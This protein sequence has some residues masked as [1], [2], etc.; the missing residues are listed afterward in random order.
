MTVAL[1]EA[2]LR[3]YY[4]AS[5]TPFIGGPYL[6]K[7][8]PK[9][10]F[11]LN[12]GIHTAQERVSYIVPISVNTIGMRGLEI[13]PKG[14]NFRIAMT[15]DSHI[16]GSGLTNKQT[17]PAQMQ[18]ALNALGSTN[19]F[20]VVNASGPSYN[21]VQQLLRIQTLLS[22]IDA[23]LLILAFNSENDI[24][25]NIE[26]LRKFMASNP[27]RPVARLDEDGKLHFDYTAPQRYYK[28][29]KWRLAAPKA[30]RP[31]Y[32][33]TALYVR[34]RVFWRSFGVKGVADPN[35]QLGL[36]HLP[37]FSA[38]HS[39]SGLSA[40]DY[41]ALWRDGWDVTAALILAMRE[42]AAAAGARFAITVLPSKI[43][44]N[45]ADIASTLVHYRGLK[46]DMTRINRMIE[47]FGNDH[48]IPVLETLKPLLA[49]R[50]AGQRGLHYQRFDSHM[51]PKSHRILANA[52]AKQLLVRKL[53]PVE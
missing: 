31:W 3:L 2:G 43:Q 1:S 19:R 37:A 45:K 25:Y 17:L 27:K 10:A 38:A 4:Y 42:S 16:F 32:E 7:P 41:E 33:S 39:P 34:G 14:N 29:H 49:A 5:L 11:T 53:V 8:D 35:I 26:G 44:V 50:D 23:D 13:G 36:P 46:L 52:L 48:G 18:K 9:I 24:H 21:T 30:N 28:R 51:T 40:V 20:E 15:G 12:P 47:A 22:K 6:Y